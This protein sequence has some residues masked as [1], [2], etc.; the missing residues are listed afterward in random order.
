MIGTGTAESLVF[1]ATGTFIAHQ[2]RISA[3]KSCRTH[4][5]MTVHHNVMLGSLFDHIEIMVVHRLTVMMVTTWNHITH[6]ACLHSIITI[7]IHQF[8]S[9]LDM[10]LIILRRRTGLMMHH[11]LH[12]LGMGIVVERLDVEIRIRCDKIEDV[13]LPHI[14]PV[15]PSYI[16]AFHQ[17]LIETVLSSEVDIAAHFLIVGSMTAIGLHLCP[18]NFVQLD[19]GEFIGVVPRTLT[20]NHFP[21]NATILCWMNP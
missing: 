8:I 7:F 18:V 21:P 14:C 10:T 11:Q 17:N 12:T 16:P 15:L 9:L 20:H 6:I 1:C 2:I 3:A 4:S 13:A 19:A 5:L